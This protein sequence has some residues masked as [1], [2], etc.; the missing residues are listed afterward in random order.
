MNFI[1]NKP[2]SKLIIEWL[3]ANAIAWPLGIL[4]A[5]ILSYAI[6]NIFHPEETNLIIGFSVGI[7][8]A[9]AQWQVLKKLMKISVLWIFVPGICIGI[10]YAWITLIH[11]SGNNLPQLLDSEWF[12]RATLFFICGALVG[13]I[14]SLLK[15]INIGR[16][17]IWILLSAIG[18]SISITINSFLFSGLIIGL[19]TLAA[20]ILMLNERKIGLPHRPESS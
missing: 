20:F 10:P 7:T 18:W 17:Y 13:I 16:S 15:S 4:L 12:F 3:V 5:I 9:F 2:N 14:Q 6:V 1:K 11:E 8:I 19:L